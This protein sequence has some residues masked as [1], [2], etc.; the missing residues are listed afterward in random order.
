[1]L[2]FG[3]FW[4]VEVVLWCDF[5]QSM[6]LLGGAEEKEVPLTRPRIWERAV[7]GAGRTMQRE[8]TL[9]LKKTKRT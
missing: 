6:G 1:M 8:L 9:R 5:G 3:A 4:V 7:N 2:F